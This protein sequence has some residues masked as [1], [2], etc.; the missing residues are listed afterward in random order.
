MQSR[1]DH[2][3]ILMHRQS[4][5]RGYF[6][7]R[8]HQPENARPPDIAKMTQETR[9]SVNC[10]DCVHSR[11][12]VKILFVFVLLLGV[13]VGKG[14]ATTTIEPELSVLSLEKSA[15]ILAPNL[16]SGNGRELIILS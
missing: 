14:S 13:Q 5:P 6:K 11:N 9:F 10:L 2:N 15:E 16:T 12:L 7:K 1:T 3:Q 4:L 8:K